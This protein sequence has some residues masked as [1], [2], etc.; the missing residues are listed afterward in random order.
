MFADYRN[1]YKPA[2]IDFGPEAEAEILRPE[3]ADSY[4]AGFKG[5]WLNG[6]ANVEFSLFDMRFDNLV[7][8]QSIDGRPGL[9]N[10]GEEH[11]KGAEIE[12]QYQLAGDL[13]LAASY[14]WHK[15]RF[16]DYVQ[17]FG[18]TPTQLKGNYLEMSPRHLGGMGIIYQ[19]PRGTYGSLVWNHVGSR[20][21]NKRN[22]ASAEAYDTLDASLGLRLDHWVFCLS[23]RNLTD[24]RPPVSES[25]LGESQYYRLP[26]RSYEFSVSRLF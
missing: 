13:R 10:A 7:V 23:G 20:Y 6:R 5:Q 16:G 25:E 18:D 8:T 19:P 15:A 11:F 14:A 2:A 1:T 17:L 26:A 12:V 22:T 4:E 9:T 3:T 21:L 24:E